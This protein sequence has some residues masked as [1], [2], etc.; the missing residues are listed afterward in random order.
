MRSKCQDLKDAKATPENSNGMALDDLS[1]D[2]ELNF[3][4]NGRVL[5]EELQGKKVLTGGAH[6]CGGKVV[7]DEILI[8]LNNSELRSC[9]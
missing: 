9:S 5:A 8:T 6:L 4:G 2:E 3:E 1:R 7:Q